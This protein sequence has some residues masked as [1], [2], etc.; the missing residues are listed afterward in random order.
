MMP[1]SRGGRGQGVCRALC[2][3]GGVQPVA[4]H[5]APLIMHIAHWMAGVTSLP[6]MLITTCTAVQIRV[7]P[8]PIPMSWGRVVEPYQPPRQHC[9]AAGSRH[10]CS[11]AAGASTSG[12]EASSSCYHETQ[13]LT[14]F[15]FKQLPQKHYLAVLINTGWLF[16]A[17]QCKTG[18]Q[19]KEASSP[20]ASIQRLKQLPLPQ[21]CPRGF[22]F[23][24]AHKEHLSGGRRQAAAWPATPVA[25]MSMQACC[26]PCACPAPP[27]LCSVAHLLSSFT[28]TLH[29]DARIARCCHHTARSCRAP[30]VCMGFHICGEPDVGADAREQSHPAPAT[31]VRARL[32]HHAHDLPAGRYA[33]LVGFR[34]GAKEWQAGACILQLAKSVHAAQPPSVLGCCVLLLRHTLTCATPRLH[35][36]ASTFVCCIGHCNVHVVHGAALAGEGKDIELRHQRKPDVVLDCVQYAEGVEW[37]QGG[38]RRPGP[39]SKCSMLLP[40]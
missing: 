5:K 36:F 14:G 27:G 38:L 9:T 18:A 21:L 34:Y 26:S 29:P 4:R 1:T 10:G 19:R 13:D 6:C 30:A 28:A 22:V 3:E 23:I 8:H 20:A 31:S 2:R 16:E 15:D 40:A 24:W 25:A 33:V 7:P 11:A 37:K 35:G 12:R 39:G 17:G 32:T